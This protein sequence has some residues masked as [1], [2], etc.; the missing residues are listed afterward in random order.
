MDLSRVTFLKWEKK[1]LFYELFRPSKILLYV[2]D[3]VTIRH[4]D[5]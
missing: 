3:L 1:K 5:N 2:K 4:D